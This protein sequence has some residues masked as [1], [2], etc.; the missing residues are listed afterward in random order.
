MSEP[1]VIVD[2]LWKKFRRGE[3]H[4]SLRDLIPAMF[5]GL[6][7]RKDRS[8]LDESEFWA[9]KDLSFEV[10]PGEAVGIIGPNGAGKSTCLKLLSRI[11]RPDR[12]ACRVQG[13]V[14]ALIEISAG[15]HQ[16]LTGRE[17]VFLQG[18]I[19]G[20]RQAEIREKFDQVVEFSGVGAFI[21]TQVKR[22]SSGMN[23]RLGF[24]IAAHLNPDVLL[25]DEVLAVGDFAFQQRCYQR[26]EQLKESGMAIVLVSH[27]LKAV[28]S[29]CERAVLLAPEGKPARIGPA[30]EITSAYLSAASRDQNENLTVRSARLSTPGQD[31][32]LAD[33][34]PPGTALR[35]ELELSSKLAIPRCIPRIEVQRTDGLLI[36]RGAP[37]GADE[38][39]V[40]KAGEPFRWTVDFR[41]NV[42]GGTYLM[43]VEL[44]D[45]S[46]VRR[47]LRLPCVASFIVAERGRGEGCASLEPRLEVNEPSEDRGEQAL[48][49]RVLTASAEEPEASEKESA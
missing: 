37:R 12:G 3:S 32:P 15:F 45:D 38:G 6:F 46:D 31:E 27:D 49:D 7:V 10:A 25:I 43:G 22:Y 33:A 29:L 23:A 5:K 14:G 9:V 16:D 13:R 26:L 24:S 39:L 19:M 48:A 44:V 20:M 40:I 47:S 35:L 8:Q 17:N 36:Y 1:A 41:A 18:S 4:D 30:V 2:Q 42:L 28:A 21:D 11:L 34:V